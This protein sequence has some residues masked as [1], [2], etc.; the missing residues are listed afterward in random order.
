MA[1]KIIFSQITKNSS[2]HAKGKHALLNRRILPSK[3]SLGDLTEI[4]LVVLD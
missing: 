3:W 1:N 4:Y 2:D